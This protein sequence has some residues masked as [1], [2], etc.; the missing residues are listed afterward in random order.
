[1]ISVNFILQTARACKVL[2]LDYKSVLGS[3]NLHK[4]LQLL[5]SEMDPPNSLFVDVICSSFYIKTYSLV[6]IPQYGLFKS[7][8]IGGYRTL[9]ALYF[10]SLLQKLERKNVNQTK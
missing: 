9:N 5:L 6:I 3:M 1:M 8:L 10:Y 7:H 2:F 4:P